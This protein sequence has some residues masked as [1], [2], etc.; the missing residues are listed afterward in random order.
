MEIR[1]DLKWNGLIKQASVGMFVFTN[2]QGKYIKK[3]I[4]D[5]SK[6]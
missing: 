1:V 4:L 6:S 2:M 5:G 3:C